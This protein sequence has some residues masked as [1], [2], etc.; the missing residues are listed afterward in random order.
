[1]MSLSLQSLSLQGSVSVADVTAL[2]RLTRLE[3]LN[4][5]GC[6]RVTDIRALET[7]SRLSTLD[8]VETNIMDVSSLAPNRSD[9]AGAGLGR[10]ADVQS[11]LL[12]AKPLDRPDFGPP[13][14]MLDWIGIDYLELG[15]GPHTFLRELQVRYALPC[16]YVR[17]EEGR[18]ES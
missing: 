5:R 4:L 7:C 14:P 2:G 17:D 3:A 1:M 18:L 16:V 12:P 8:L 6:A 9:L 11:T 15:P 13:R 10:R